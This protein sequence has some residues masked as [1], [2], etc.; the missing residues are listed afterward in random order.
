MDHN[1]KLKGLVFPVIIVIFIWLFFSYYSR[2]STTISVP[3]PFGII[4]LLLIVTIA[5]I[6]RTISLKKLILSLIVGLF[7]WLSFSFYLSYG[8]CDIL[9][10]FPFV[11]IPF[12]ILTI[13]LSKRVDAKV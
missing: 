10:T 7:I 3:S 11:I 6:N 4:V 9:S 5:I 1:I 8:S 12:L 13:A 2:C